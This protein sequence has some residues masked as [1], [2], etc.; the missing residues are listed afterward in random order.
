MKLSK[1]RTLILILYVTD[2]RFREEL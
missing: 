2:A 1:Y